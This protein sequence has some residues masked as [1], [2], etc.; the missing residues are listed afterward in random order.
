MLTAV[1]DNEGS[2]RALNV[3][4]SSGCRYVILYYLSPPVTF[5][6]SPFLHMVLTLFYSMQV[7]SFPYTVQGNRCRLAHMHEAFSAY[8]FP[9]CPLLDRLLRLEITSSANRTDEKPFGTL[10]HIRSAQ[11]QRIGPYSPTH[12]TV[13][14]THRTSLH[15][16]DDPSL[17]TM[18]GDRE[19]SR[20]MK[21]SY[22]V[23]GSCWTGRPRRFEGKE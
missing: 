15:A 22:K 13:L 18:H 11:I 2:C 16:P 5:I 9:A 20:S 7:S 14:S 19:L 4:A 3:A 6:V 12:S 21:D 10:V 1:R 8:P 17:A 23:R